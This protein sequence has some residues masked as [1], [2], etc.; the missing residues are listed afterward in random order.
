MHHVH[1]LAMGMASGEAIG[2]MK[3]LYLSLHFLKMRLQY[4]LIA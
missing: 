3:R 2:M 1:G 4:C